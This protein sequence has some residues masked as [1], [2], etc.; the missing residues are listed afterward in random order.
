M[1]EIT[2]VWDSAALAL[3]TDDPR[4]KAA[5][6]RLA[7]KAVVTMKAKTPVSPVFPVYAQPVPLGRSAGPVY[8]GGLTLAEARA[9]VVKAQA[10]VT[11]TARHRLL[12]RAINHLDYADTAQARQLA[13]AELRAAGLAPLARQVQGIRH[14]GVRRMSGP[15]R[16]RL[17]RAG[18]LPLNVSGR[19]RES[20]RAFRQRD[21]SVIIGPTADYAR[22]VNDGTRPHIIR[23]H[24]PWPL[25]NRVTGQIFG[26]IVHHPGHQ[27]GAHFIE[28]TAEALGGARERA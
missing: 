24:G 27:P 19:L 25:R 17:R 2:M 3:V 20:V 10:G 14:K 21:G 5:M 18:D 12:Q 26:R 13:A 1:A 7:A 9:A 11:D 16:P 28:R 15:D 22:Y 6:D 4:V 23:S 8:G